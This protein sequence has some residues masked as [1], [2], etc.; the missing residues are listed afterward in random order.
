MARLPGPG[1]GFPLFLIVLGLAIIGAA[2][3]YGFGRT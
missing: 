1:D 2:L 3:C